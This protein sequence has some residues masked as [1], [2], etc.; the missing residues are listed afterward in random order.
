MGPYDVGSDVKKSSRERKKQTAIYQN[1][2]SHISED[3]N[4]SC[5]CI[6]KIFVKLNKPPLYAFREYVDNCYCKNLKSYRETVTLAWLHTNAKC[7][8]DIVVHCS[9]LLI[10]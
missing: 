1:T 6:I 7:Q 10:T 2:W 4:L 3:S 8:D 5:T 9:R